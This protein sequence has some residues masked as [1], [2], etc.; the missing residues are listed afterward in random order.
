MV[1]HCIVLYLSGQGVVRIVYQFNKVNRR[2]KLLWFTIMLSPGHEDEEVEQ[3]HK[4]LDSITAK[5]PMKDVLVVQ[6]D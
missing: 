4:Q 6:S 5:T 1:L 3:L 2:L